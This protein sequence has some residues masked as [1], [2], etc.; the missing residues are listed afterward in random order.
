M[1]PF[2]LKLTLR[3]SNK[4]RALINHTNEV[5]G[6]ITHHDGYIKDIKVRHKGDSYSVRTFNDVN[7]YI[8]FHT[9]AY[10][11]QMKGFKCNTIK[12]RISD[13]IDNNKL[14]DALYLFETDIIK[15][16]PPSPKD[17]VYIL[18]TGN[19]HV[20]VAQEYMYQVQ[21]KK[22]ENTQTYASINSRIEDDYYE[23]MW[24]VKKSSIHL[25]NPDNIKKLVERCCQYVKSVT[26]YAR[27]HKYKKCV[28]RYGCSIHCA[29][30]KQ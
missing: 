7:G 18:S 15:L 9:H 10:L 12:Q 4:L 5:S 6:S 23:A 13:L 3:T 27:L 29:K 19:N 2:K 16:H 24:G 21:C 17:L 11:Q 8:S 30:W 14:N 26:N 20:V 25:D 28:E 1:K 22:N